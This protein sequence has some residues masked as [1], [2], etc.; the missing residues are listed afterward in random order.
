MLEKSLALRRLRSFG[1]FTVIGIK[2]LHFLKYLMANNFQVLQTKT[3]NRNLRIFAGLCLIVHV[4][5]GYEILPLNQFKAILKGDRV[6][7]TSNAL[8]GLFPETYRIPRRRND[9]NDSVEAKINFIR[10]CDRLRSR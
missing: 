8:F 1:R 10:N 2:C 7:E 4:C 5:D 3:E 9:E 6:C